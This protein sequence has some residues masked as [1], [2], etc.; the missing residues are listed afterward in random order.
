MDFINM[1]TPVASIVI[2][3]ILIGQAFKAVFP[4]VNVD[5]VQIVTMVVGGILGIV[6]ALTG[7]LGFENLHMFDS[8]AI[9]VVSGLASNGVY[10]GAKN[11]L[12]K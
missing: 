8:F 6:G 5:K 9:G 10:S 12:G 3:C 7:L 1:F 2:I 4:S 11:L